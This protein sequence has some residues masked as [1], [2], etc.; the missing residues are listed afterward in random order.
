MA[1]KTKQGR[2]T[3]FLE[4]TTC[5]ESGIP[6]VNRYVTQKNKKNTAARIELSKYCRYERK[7]TTHK[8]TK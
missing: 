6:G 4:C 3:I 2:M 1:K 5:R 8:E 7:Q